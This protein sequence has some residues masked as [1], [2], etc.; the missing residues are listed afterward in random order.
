MKALTL[1]LNQ[2][3]EY[4]LK[5]QFEKLFEVVGR[6]DA[7]PESKRLA[8]EMCDAATEFMRLAGLFPFLPLLLAR[9][10]VAVRGPQEGI[11]VAYIRPSYMKGSMG[12]LLYDNVRVNRAGYNQKPFTSE[13]VRHPVIRIKDPSGRNGIFMEPFSSVVNG[14]LI[15]YLPSEDYVRKERR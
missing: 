12:S 14:R 8:R 2:L 11:A 6:F 15:E 5:Q 3:D 7:S 13:L 9:R 4:G 10:A 1:G